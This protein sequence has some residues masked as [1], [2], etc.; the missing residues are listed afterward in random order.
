MPF[1][2][3]S[4]PLTAREIE[5]LQA[6]ADGRTMHSVAELLCVSHDTIKTHV[7]KIYAKLQAR[8]REEAL[9]QARKERLI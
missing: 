7:R 1:G 2:S 9:A 8:N 6:M 4:F 3:P 5:V